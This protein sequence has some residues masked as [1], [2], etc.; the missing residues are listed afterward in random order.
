MRLMS[1]QMAVL[2]LKVDVAT[3]TFTASI[4]T[5][6]TKCYILQET[7]SMEWHPNWVYVFKIANSKA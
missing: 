3:F 7:K 4:Q 2:Q 1:Q 6:S 5:Y